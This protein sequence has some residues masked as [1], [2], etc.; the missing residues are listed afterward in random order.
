MACGLV[1]NRK[2]FNFDMASLPLN[3]CSVLPSKPALDC[4]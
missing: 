2:K 3:Q 4:A 1:A